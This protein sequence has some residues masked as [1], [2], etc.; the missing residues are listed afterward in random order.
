MSY[1]FQ[2]ASAFNGDLSDWNT[3]AVTNM[4]YMFQL[5]SAF[6]G[7]LSDWNTAAVMNMSN[8]F[9]HAYTF[10]SD[11]GSWDVSNVR[12]M[13][14]MFEDAWAFSGNLSQWQVSRHTHTLNL[15]VGARSFDVDETFYGHWFFEAGWASFNRMSKMPLIQWEIARNMSDVLTILVAYHKYSTRRMFIEPEGE[16]WFDMWYGIIDDSE[17]LHLVVEYDLIDQWNKFCRKHRRSVDKI[18]PLMFVV[19]D[20]GVMYIH[21]EK[22][23][24]RFTEN[25]DNGVINQEDLENKI[26]PNEMKIFPHGT[27][28]ENNYIS[29][30][31]APYLTP[32]PTD[33]VVPANEEQQRLR[34]RNIV[35]FEDGDVDKYLEEDD[36]HIVI[37]NSWTGEVFCHSKEYIRD[38][39]KSGDNIFYMCPDTER[40]S[41]LH[42]NVRETLV[43]VHACTFPFFITLENARHIILSDCKYFSLHVT[44]TVFQYTMSKDFYHGV[45]DAEFGAANNC[46]PGTS[47][48]VY[49]LR[50]RVRR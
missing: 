36:D 30:R 41:I 25:I 33:W 9:S 10:N 38:N 7:D 4:S 47:K 35:L 12:T 31:F 1:M 44:D 45:S 13:Q 28:I 42:R 37:I 5:A 16:R 20:S 24:D 46:G 17:F 11:L 29:K 21:M 50:C 48:T 2:R 32:E 8:M 22:D 23:Y 34:C 27:P 14:S 6:N 49:E 18:I 26:Q 15:F 43:R 40:R 3:A 39:L 19:Y